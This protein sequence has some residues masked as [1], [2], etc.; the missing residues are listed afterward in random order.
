MGIPPLVD[1]LT[2]LSSWVHGCS[3]EGVILRLTADNPEREIRGMVDPHAIGIHD[4]LGVRCG[5][6]PAQRRRGRS[7]GLRS[8]RDDLRPP[9]SVI[10]SVGRVP[11]E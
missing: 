8:R 3:G 1:G 2:T 6:Q 7:R 9:R 5:D 4:K 10:S 11:G